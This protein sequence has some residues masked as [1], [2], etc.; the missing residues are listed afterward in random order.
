MVLFGQ[1]TDTDGQKWF[2]G[3]VLI[4]DRHV[5]TAALCMRPEQAATVVARIG[6]HDLTTFR[7]VHH[8]ERNT[9]SIGAKICA[10]SRDDK[11]RDACRGDSGGPLM[12]EL[13]DG[14]Y[15]LTGIVST[16]VGCDNPEFPGSYT[17]VSSYID[18][19]LGNLLSTNADNH[20]TTL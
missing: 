8:Q 14:S 6:D 7:D 4:T 16:G 9:Y 5:L 20:M 11:P 3:G 12:V 18:W 15:R 1:R 10:G 17:K 13:P 2:C 19:I